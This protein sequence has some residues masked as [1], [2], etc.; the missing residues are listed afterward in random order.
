MLRGGDE[1]CHSQQ[2]N[3]NTYCQDN[4]LSWMNW[5]LDSSAEEFRDFVAKVIRLRHRL[6][7][8]RR[9]RFFQGRK[10]RGSAIVDVVWFNESGHEMRASDWNSPRSGILGVEFSGQM[11]GEVDD[12]GKRVQGNSVLMLFNASHETLEFPLPSLRK[13]A[14]WRLLIDSADPQLAGKKLKNAGSY[15]VTARS[16]IACEQVGL[17][18]KVLDKLSGR[19]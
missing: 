11:H 7:V 2:G 19:S 3:N 1:L 8:L 13:Y 9:R 12:R 15:S 18:P 17:L 16:I 6:P 10:I 5:E 14:F 4:Q